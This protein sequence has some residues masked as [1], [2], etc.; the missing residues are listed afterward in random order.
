[1]RT[2]WCSGTRLSG[3]STLSRSL[4]YTVTDQYWPKARM[5]W[6]LLILSSH[7]L[8]DQQYY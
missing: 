1:M 3:L 2:R 6:K 5:A 4:C 7:F 8:L